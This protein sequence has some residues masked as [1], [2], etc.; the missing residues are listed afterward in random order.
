VEE[1]EEVVHGVELEL[2]VME[3]EAGLTEAVECGMNEWGEVFLSAEDVGDLP[4]LWGDDGKRGGRGEEVH[5]RTPQ[6]RLPSAARRIPSS[7]RR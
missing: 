5:R 6:L 7:H 1:V 4:S 2:A 3:V